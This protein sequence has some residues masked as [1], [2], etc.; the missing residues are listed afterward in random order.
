MADLATEMKAELERERF[1]VRAELIADVPIFAVYDK[2]PTFERVL[3]ALGEMRCE[4]TCRQGRG[5]PECSVRVCCFDKGIAGCWECGSFESC[6]KLDFLKGRNHG[7]AVI[8]NLRLLRD[9]PAI[10]ISGG[11]RWYL[12]EEGER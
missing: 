3:F 5:P 9:D 10:N 2:Y 11:R 6:E 8:R 1:N 12:G 4:G 7:G